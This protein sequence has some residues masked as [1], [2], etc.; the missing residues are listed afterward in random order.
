MF[1]IPSSILFSKPYSCLSFFHC[2][3][4]SW[5]LIHHA[6]LFLQSS[7]PY[8]SSVM[9]TRDHSYLVMFSSPCSSSIMFSS[10]HSFS[11]MFSRPCSS[12]VMIFGSCLTK[13]KNR[14]LQAFF[15]RTYSS[16]AIFFNLFQSWSLNIVLILHL[17]FRV[18]SCSTM[19]SRPFWL[20]RPNPCLLCISVLVLVH[21]VWP[22]SFFSLFLSS[23]EL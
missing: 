14:V 2:V 9:F 6:G 19:F 16:S 15:S 13:N 3:F 21:A 7:C 23:C 4:Q 10:S 20:S 22:C 8:S 11:V 1:F 17:L 18:C 5:F 12:Y